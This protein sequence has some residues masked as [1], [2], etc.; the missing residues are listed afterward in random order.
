[1][2]ASATIDRSESPLKLDVANGPELTGRHWPVE[3]AVGWIY[4]VH[5]L[6]D[7]VGRY[8]PLVDHCRRRGLGVLGFDQPGHGQSPGK[9]G[10]SPGYQEVLELLAAGWRW[11]Q[12]L[13]PG[14][15]GCLYGH[16]LGGNYAMQLVLR[17]LVQP[18]SLVLSS[19]WI[20]L[21][22]D[23]PA[24]QV[25]L[26]RLA[27]MIYPGLTLASGLDVTALSRDTSVVQ[28]YRDDPLTHDR[29]SPRIFFPARQ[30]A[31]EI[32]QQ[33]ATLVTPTLLMHGDAD[34][35]TSYTASE[36]LARQ[37]QS[38]G[39]PL[40]WIPWP[41]GYHELHHEPGAEALLDQVIDW[42]LSQATGSVSGI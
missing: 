32:P 1:M 6:G 20:A 24:W 18:T 15:P 8:Q 9:R 33:L 23:P 39:V 36:S 16:S 14:L 5:G 30:A 17:Q 3:G 26:G 31:S 7:H 42:V 4:L 28:A 35:I 19:P 2:P 34:R 10:S 29:V 13:Y 27:G 12:S 11:G 37:A 22:E 25:W 38:Q 40:D 41:G 21:A